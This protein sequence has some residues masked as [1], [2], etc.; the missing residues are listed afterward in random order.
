MAASATRPGSV[1]AARTAVLVL[2][3]LA[4][5]ALRL[6]FINAE[7]FKND[8]A[9]F[10]AWALTL[11]AHPLAE[12]YGKTSFADYPPGYFYVLWLI[13]HL[14]A[15]FAQS[16][17]AHQYA[18]LKIF[19]KL[20]AIVMD[21]ADAALIYALVVRFAS[22]RWA[23]AA[24]AVYLLNPATI[25]ISAYWGQVDSVA[26]AFVLLA[27]L[28]ILDADRWGPSATYA[29]VGAWLALGYSVL[30]KPQGALIGA[31]FLAYPFA[32]LDPAVTRR[33]LAGTALGVAAAVVL[34]CLLALPFHPGSPLA[35]LQ[36]LFERYRFG[37]NVYPYN[38]VNAFNLYS[39]FRPFWQPDNA[40]I[41]IGS[42]SL[43]AM[44]VWGVL[45]VVAA[46]VL[47]VARYL[48]V[49]TQAAFLEG[50][51]LLAFAFF[52]LATRM[53]ERY[54]FNA[55]VLL[56]VLMALGRR[57][58][59]GTIVVS[60]TLLLNLAYS[61][62]YLNVMTNHVAGVDPT[63]LWPAAHWLSGLNVAAFFALGYIY[64]G[65]TLEG[66]PA[67]ERPAPLERDAPAARPWFAPHEG[68]LGFTR[69]DHALAA[70]LGIA[71]F[72]ICV[73]WYWIPGEKIFDEIY[74]A[75]AGEEYLK[76]VELFEWTHPPLTK[77]LITLSMLLFGGLHGLGDTSVGWRFLN[78]VVGAVTVW[79]LY[80]FAKRL[81]G[82]TLFAAAAAGLLVFDGFHFVQSRIATPEITVA[83]FSLATLYAFYRYWCAAQVRREPLVPG[84][85][86]PRFWL[87]IAGGIVAAAAFTWLVNLPGGAPSIGA[88]AAAFLY[89]L[90]G[91]YLIARLAVPRSLPDAGAQTSYA[92]G[93][94]VVTGR[95]QPQ[96]TSAIGEAIKTEKQSYEDDGLRI[97]YARNGTMRYAT[98]EGEAQFSPAGTMETAVGTVVPRDGWL[99]LGVL[100]LAAAAVGDS[101]WNGLFDFFVVWGV[102]AAVTAQR[103]F[104]RP[105][106]WGNPYGFPLDLVV[107]GICFVSAT[108]YALS[109]IP[110]FALGHNLSDLVALQQQMF[111]YHDNLRAT[112]PYGSSWWQWPLLQR[113]ISYYYHDFR[114]GAALQNGA[115]CCVAEI[116]ALPNPAVWWLGLLSVPYIAYLAWRER[117]KGFALLVTAYL[118]QWLPW[119]ATPRVAFEY[120]FY[121]NLAIICIANAAL[122]QRLW[123]SVRWGRWA[124]WAYLALV[125]GLFAYFY[126]ILA[127]VQIT[128]DAWHQR[129][130]EPITKL[131]GGNWI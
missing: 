24:A 104:K 105:A 102:V 23:T 50:A 113:P 19:V 48:Q 90:A 123:R 119:I 86:G 20:P 43:G 112:H 110:Y 9:S 73:A 31:L 130:W 103:F 94:L 7:G 70:G 29:I 124:V 28:L 129:M 84:R 13:G 100:A 10:E 26:T 71:S 97:T 87:V 18:L 101:K 45:L 33:R 98:P 3:G 127:G 49:R 44:S 116:L 128:Y 88:R 106:V 27:L 62:S 46:A 107:V 72:L 109:Y 65:G 92:E 85:F 108:I 64:L 82:S 125:V 120:H 32:A 81:L 63:M 78:V 54:V 77:L 37:S 67:A 79:L 96:V 42:V 95:G 34:A 6:L 14:Y 83:L 76:H 121:P 57:F 51:M 115:A 30:I 1:G 35:A 15:P 38:S 12:F 4:A 25:F 39:V 74:Y 5:L 41:L 58:V 2:V 80:A 69:L 16:D 60:L 93:T 59:Y 99:W 22:A 17:A 52:I 131:I 53:H 36:W 114:S 47:V 91:A 122:L 55:F 126:P 21:F 8:V 56:I 117:S 89:V 118:L 68:L 40:P 111:G 61:L 75:R 11:A 66:T